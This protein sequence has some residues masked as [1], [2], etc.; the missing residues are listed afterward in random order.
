MKQLPI[1]FTNRMKVLL[2]D[3]YDAYIKAVNEPAVKAFRI[4]TSKISVDDFE[5]INHFGKDKFSY[6]DGGYYLNFEKVGNH[7]FHHA[8]MIYVQEPAAMAPAECV[9]I[10]PDAYVLDMCA[11]PGGKSTQIKKAANAAFL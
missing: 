10:E 4:N 5:K 8:G 7:P 6:V 3:E 2:G 1:D 11:A 9:D